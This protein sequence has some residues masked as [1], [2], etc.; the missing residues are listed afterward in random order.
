MAELPAL[1]ASRIAL[2]PTAPSPLEVATIL[3]VWGDD[4]ALFVSQ[5]A[6]EHPTFLQRVDGAHGALGPV[7]SLTDEYVFGAFARGTDL[8]VASTHMATIC[9]TTYRGSAIVSRGCEAKQGTVLLPLDDHFVLL[10]AKPPDPDAKPPTGKDAAKNK[11]VGEPAQV[12]PK[13]SIRAKA[14]KKRPKARPE[15]KVAADPRKLSLDRQ[16]LTADGALDGETGGS[17]LVFTAPMAGMELVAGSSNGTRARALYYEWAGSVKNAKTGVLG[18]AR[19]ALGSL[20]ATGTYDETSRS[21]LPETDLMFGYL[22]EHQEPRLLT[23]KRG[24][25]YLGVASPHGKCE[26]TVVSPF[27]MPLIPDDALCALDPGGYFDVADRV[28]AAQKAGTSVGR[29]GFPAPKLAAAAFVKARR[30]YAQGE[31]DPMRTAAWSDRGYAMSGD[32][33]LTFTS[34]DAPT[35]LPRPLVAERSRIA[36]GA[37]APD[38]SGIAALEHGLVRVD[39]RGTTTLDAIATVHPS[40]LL[41]ADVEEGTRRSA[42]K[43][44]GRWW[45]SRGELRALEGPEGA[46]SK[47]LRLLPPDSAV[48]VGGAESGLVIE[49]ASGALRVE[50][51]DPKSYLPA[52]LAPFFRAMAAHTRDLAPHLRDTESP[53]RASLTQLYRVDLDAFETA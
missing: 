40:L 37:F 29:T 50:R 35:A 42:A 27:S 45:Q 49:T 9:L 26:A 43:V 18:R 17:G 6:G 12:K 52:V 11:K 47:A 30:T 53:A 20:D 5:F 19:L 4:S 15:P 22:A 31:T 46:R 8:T 28:R 38:G 34:I 33:A 41:R 44:G 13:S 7:V 32:D 3:A 10:S 23:T 39:Q 1:D 51:F 25:L 14:I 36:W 21:Q 48:L 16:L 2:G 24:A